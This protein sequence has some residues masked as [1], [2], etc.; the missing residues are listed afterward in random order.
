[1]RS[2]SGHPK[3]KSVTHI[4]STCPAFPRTVVR[5]VAMAYCRGAAAAVPCSTR[6]AGLRLPPAREAL[7]LAGVIVAIPLE[8]SL[9][10]LRPAFD[11]QV[12]GA[13]AIA[14]GAWLA[15]WSSSA[16]VVILVRRVREF[17]STPEPGAKFRHGGSSSMAS[18][19]RPT[20]P[21]NCIR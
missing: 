16:A 18:T 4:C 5:R 21:S 9:C 2:A 17:A 12:A 10:R 1:M 6:T 13:G 7:V 3:A 14:I 8:F 20:K 15:C 11:R 19:P